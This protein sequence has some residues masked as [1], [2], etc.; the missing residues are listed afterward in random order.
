MAPRARWPGASQ[1]QTAREDCR[2]SKDL[3]GTRNQRKWH[4]QPA[5]RA[6]APH[7]GWKGATNSVCFSQSTLRASETHERGL[8]GAGNEF[9]IRARAKRMLSGCSVQHLI[10]EGDLWGSDGEAA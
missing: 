2:Y 5:E 6:R 9:A 8:G 10:L 4:S 1:A 7:T 3:S